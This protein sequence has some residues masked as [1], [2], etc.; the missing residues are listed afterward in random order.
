MEVDAYFLRFRDVKQAH[1]NSFSI[2]MGWAGLTGA[3]QCR[4]EEY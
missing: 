4:A 3:L 2:I 1:L